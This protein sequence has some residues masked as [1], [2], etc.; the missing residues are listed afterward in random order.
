MVCQQL[1]MLYSE[2][3]QP[4]YPPTLRYGESVAEHKRWRALC[5]GLAS[6]ITPIR[7]AIN[8]AAWEKYPDNALFAENP[9][10]TIVVDVLTKTS[11]FNGEHHLFSALNG[12]HTD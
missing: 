11:T 8:S 1:C 2:A 7:S 6:S 4:M 10:G 5:V 3:L 9:S 12:I